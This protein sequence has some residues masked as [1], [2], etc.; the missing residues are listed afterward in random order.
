MARKLPFALSETQLQALLAQPNVGSTT[1]LRDRVMMQVMARAGLR[2]SEVTALRRQEITWGGPGERPGITILDGKG[3]K[4]R[5]VPVGEATQGWL[6][7]WDAERYSYCRSAFFHTIKATGYS[8]ANTPLSTR[9]VQSMVKRYAEAAGLPTTGNRRVTPHTLRHTYATWLIRSGTNLEAVRR[10][11]GH[12][13][14]STTQRY[15]HISDPELEETVWDLEAEEQE[16]TTLDG[17][18]SA[19]DLALARAINS[20]NGEAKAALAEALGLG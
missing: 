3:E 10:L 4:D 8:E 2:V 19:Q 6:R 1:G 13:D 16:Q 11:L 14:I 17:Q 5:H 9:T 15:L 12:A 20:M 18:P 7:R